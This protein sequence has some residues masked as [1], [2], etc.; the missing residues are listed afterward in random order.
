[1]SAD[2]PWWL[3]S[4]KALA[5]SQ[6]HVIEFDVVSRSEAN[7]LGALSIVS[8]AVYEFVPPVPGIGA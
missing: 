5:K 1:M 3:K 7:A 6:V 2:I 4:V 8:D